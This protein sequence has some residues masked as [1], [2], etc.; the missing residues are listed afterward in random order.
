MPRDGGIEADQNWMGSPVLIPACRQLDVKLY[1][2]PGHTFEEH[3]ASIEDTWLRFTVGIHWEYS[4][5]G[6]DLAG[7]ILQL[8]SGMP[9]KQYVQ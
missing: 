2:L 3:I 4:N 7:Y 5:L 1:R 9:F 8:R 6:I